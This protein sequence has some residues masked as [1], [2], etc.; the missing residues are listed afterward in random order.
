MPYERYHSFSV[1]D[2]AV[3]IT[4]NSIILLSNMI[5]FN[6]VFSLLRVTDVMLQLGVVVDRSLHLHST[7]RRGLSKVVNSYPIKPIWKAY[8]RVCESLCHDRGKVVPDSLFRTLRCSR[9][10]LPVC[11]KECTPTMCD[12]LWDVRTL[13]SQYWSIL[14]RRSGDVRVDTFSAWHQPM[15]ACSWFDERVPR[16]FITLRSISLYF[17]CWY[18]LGS[19]SSRLSYA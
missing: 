2:T 9:F 5:H 18:C 15:L 1:R 3:H 19:V 8:L 7:S 4:V 11:S 17:R 6:T 16:Y 13:A 10:L 12:Q 14:I